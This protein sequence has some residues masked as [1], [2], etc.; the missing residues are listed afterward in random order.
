MRPQRHSHRLQVQ[1]RLGVGAAVAGDSEMR[2]GGERV[3]V[4]VEQR[5]HLSLVRNGSAVTY[6][7]G[8]R[9][10]LL[11]LAHLGVWTA[12]IHHLMG[13]RGAHLGRVKVKG[14]VKVK[15]TGGAIYPH[16]QPAATQET[17]E[18]LEIVT[19]SVNGIAV[20]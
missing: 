13:V 18:T 15:V 5:Q 9:H 12:A 11:P 17:H 4:A 2:R 7:Q 3:V 14:K 16:P 1:V 8:A 6:L 19:V 20:A 10:L